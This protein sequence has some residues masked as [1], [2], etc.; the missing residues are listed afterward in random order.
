MGLTQTGGAIKRG[1]REVRQ[2]RLS[3]LLSLKK[4]ANMSPAAIM[5][6]FLPIVLK[7]GREP[8]CSDETKSRLTP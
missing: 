4:Q 6:C 5:T 3:V 7:L 1:V 8:T 2:K